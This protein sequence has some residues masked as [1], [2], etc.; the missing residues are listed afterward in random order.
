MWNPKIPS[1]WDFKLKATIWISWKQEKFFSTA[2][3][4]ICSQVQ[5]DHA[6]FHTHDNAI[7][8][9]LSFV[10]IIL[11]W[12]EHMSLQKHLLPSVNCLCTHLVQDLWNPKLSHI[13]EYKD[14]LLMF[15]VCGIAAVAT[16]LPFRTMDLTSPSFL[17]L[18]WVASRVLCL[19]HV[20]SLASIFLSTHAH[21]L[22]KQCCL[23]TEHIT[24][25]FQHLAHLLPIK[26][27]P[28]TL[29]LPWCKPVGQPHFLLNSNSHTDSNVT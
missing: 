8:E 25:Q 9:V 15:I 28:Q 27:I 1:A 7:Q 20:S 6:I 17:S 12:W 19:N 14:S 2:S 3:S 21:F 16:L 4:V 24:C 11:Q 29:V 22:E 10:V 5:N 18:S 23:H 13:I 26:N